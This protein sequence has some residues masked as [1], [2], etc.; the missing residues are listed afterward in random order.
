MLALLDPS[1]E[2]KLSFEEGVLRHQPIFTLLE[3]VL[4]LLISALRAL[5]LEREQVIRVQWLPY[6]MIELQEVI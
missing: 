6:H 3:Q 5:I 1:L 2:I 4:A